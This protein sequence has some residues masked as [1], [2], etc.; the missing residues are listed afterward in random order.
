[1]G[2]SSSKI[3]LNDL[4]EYKVND[5]SRKTICRIKINNIFKGYG[6][7]SIT[8]STKTKVLIADTDTL[9][10]KNFKLNDNIELIINDI[11][12]K[13][14]KE[15]SREIY[16][17]DNYDIII[18]EIK[19]I[20]INGLDMKNFLEFD[21]NI[22]VSNQN[23]KYKNKEI[24]ILK[25]NLN[26]KNIPLGFIKS[27]NET[28]Y[29]I[30]HNCNNIDNGPFSFPILL[31][32]SLK[33]IGFNQSKHNGILLKK[34]L[35]EFEELKCIEIIKKEEERRSKI[36]SKNIISVS[37]TTIKKK[38]EDQKDIF[39]ESKKSDEIIKLVNKNKED[40]DK[41]KKI[42]IYKTPV[43]INPNNIDK[44][45]IKPVKSVVLLTIEVKSEDIHK[46]IYF[47]DNLKYN[48]DNQPRKNGFLKEIEEIKNEIIINI[49]DPN[50]KTDKIKFDNKFNPN[51]NGNYL[52]DIEIPKQCNDL[53][54]MLYGCTQIIEADLSNFVFSEVTNMND[55]FNYCI[56]LK[57]IKFN[58]LDIL[59]VNN[60][61]YMFNY[62]K[63]LKKI[64]LSN[65]HTE[66]VTHMGGMFQHCENL[67]EVN[68]EN[69]DTKKVVQISCMF[70]NCYN[71]E[72]ILVSNKFVPSNVKFNN[73][74]FYGCEK[75]EKELLKV[76]QKLK[77]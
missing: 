8:P 7:L 68:I 39:K 44:K 55:M 26:N 3:Q 40:M 76:N 41:I 59:N 13:I 49:T 12:Y 25:N 70:I 60:M 63:N 64:D 66:N 53:G 50:D 30:E 37:S 19:D 43:E 46:D 47:L 42:T 9:T 10:E 48:K 14:N 5:Q 16:M 52:I 61:N 73:W 1:M 28:N 54:F 56:N 69:F 77:H 58:H 15:I 31:L 51:I 36:N 34:L 24:Y 27:I 2:S 21:D 38:E 75:E 72:K 18:I 4:Q 17:N 65:F 6:F 11:E 45:V 23:K 20:D 32:K 71:L 33:V 67:E 74:V 62:C 29:K 57:N 35:D 22:N